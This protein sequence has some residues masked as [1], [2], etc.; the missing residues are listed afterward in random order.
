M[1]YINYIFGAVIFISL[2]ANFFLWLFIWKV[3]D[4]AVNLN[5]TSTAMIK[6]LDNLDEEFAIVWASVHKLQGIGK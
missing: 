1:E 4:A 5:G 3:H 2:A 6:M